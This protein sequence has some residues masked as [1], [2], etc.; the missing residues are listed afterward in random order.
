MSYIL[1]AL[2]R[3]EAER[4]RGSVPGLHSQP[5]PG[6]P[7][8][9]RHGH[10]A[11][12]WA[13]AGAAILLLGALAWTLAGRGA[14]PAAQ[15]LPRAAPPAG[16]A[17]MLATAPPPPIP[18]L[19]AAQV[20]AVPSTAAATTTGPVATTTAAHDARPAR[21]SEPAAA[22]AASAA[23]PAA[24]PAQAAASSAGTPPPAGRIVSYEQLPDDV[25]R[26]MPQLNIGGAIYSDV[27][28]NRIL[29]VG[30]LLLHEGEDVAPGVTLEKIKPRSAVLRWRDLHYEVSF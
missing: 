4:E 17:P 29:M 9:A 20:R 6:A 16:S 19:P 12:L 5:A 15:P 7:P 25:R 2:R 11:A 26:Q 22:P 30:G 14:A 3:A 10:P 28:A 21:A 23:R 8:A 24:P 18:A 27:A 13:A 1:D